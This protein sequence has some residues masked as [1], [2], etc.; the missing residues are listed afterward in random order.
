MS[1]IGHKTIEKRRAQEDVYRAMEQSLAAEKRQME[2]ATWENSSAARQDGRNRVDRVKEIQAQQEKEVLRRRQEL[3]NLYN[4]EMDAWRTEVMSR[5]ETQED[6]KSRYVFTNK[7]ML[8]EFSSSFSVLIVLSP[9]VIRL[10]S[11]RY[12]IMERAYALRDA[13]EETR[14]KVVQER[15]D[16][17]WRDACDD[18][19]LLDSKALTLHMSK[20]RHQQIQDKIMRN[21]ELSR[22]ENDFMIE[23]QRQLEVMHQKDQDK[24]AKQHK[25]DL[26][27]VCN[28]LPIPSSSLQSP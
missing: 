6:R 3:A 19:R 28:L 2:I 14:R 5:V 8:I 20:E 25:A 21:K 26:D 16:E 22:N 27:T 10:L 23:W 1:S 15:L 24:R 4:N 7:P 9:Y 18:A 12:R 17:Q 13:R 11:S